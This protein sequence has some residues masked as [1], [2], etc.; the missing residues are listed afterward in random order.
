MTRSFEPLAAAVGE[1]RVF[2]CF[3]AL[4]GGLALFAYRAVPE[5]RGKS[6][7]E[8]AAFFDSA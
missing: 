7:P 5:T 4:C 2:G 6:L 3:A 8:I 1:G